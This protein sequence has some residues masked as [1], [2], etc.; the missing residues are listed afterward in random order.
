M[1]H[2]ERDDVVEPAARRDVQRPMPALVRRF[3]IVPDVSNRQ[4]LL[5]HLH[6]TPVRALCIAGITPSR[7]A[8]LLHLVG[9]LRAAM[10]DLKIVVSRLGPFR[11]SADETRMVQQAGADA[12]ARSLHE[13]KARLL[14]ALEPASERAAI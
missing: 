14:D 5:D 6:R 13:T 10:P 1:L 11:P 2:E 12:V 9:R 8:M 3:E 7:T 4:S